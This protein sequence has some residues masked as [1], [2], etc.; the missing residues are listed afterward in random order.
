MLMCWLHY[1]DIIGL[2][3]YWNTTLYTVT[4]LLWIFQHL[5]S[6]LVCVYLGFK[7]VPAIA[8]IEL[9]LCQIYFQ[10][11]LW[12]VQDNYEKESHSV[13]SVFV[14][15]KQAFLNLQ[16]RAV[17]SLFIT[18]C[19]LLIYTEVTQKLTLVAQVYFPLNILKSHIS[20]IC[21]SCWTLYPYSAHI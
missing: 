8:L 16:A 15:L 19:L 10:C 6:V 17:F 4:S 13:L 3:R 18:R 14:V 12:I 5:F 11:S 1:H 9:K 20:P 2:V 21:N 7:H